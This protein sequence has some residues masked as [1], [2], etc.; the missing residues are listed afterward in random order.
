VK[1]RFLGT[2][3]AESKNT[4]LSTFI[5]DDIIAIESGSLTSEISFVEQE[6]IKAILLSHGHYDHIRGVPAFAF[7][8]SCHT[9]RVYATS[10]TLK[11]LS[12]HLV[13]GLIYPKFTEYTPICG[14]TSLEFVTIEPFIPIEI[15]GYKILALPVKHTLDAVGFE[16]TSKDGKK[17]FYT[18]DTGPGLS[19]IWKHVTSKQI[20]ID[21]T[22]PNKLEDTAKNS[23]HLCPNMLKEELLNFNRINGYFPEIILIHLT[24][25]FKREIRDEM[26]KI[27]EEINISFR[28]AKEGEEIII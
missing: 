12:S 22:F 6:K 8:N 7:N 28:I 9:T 15:E 4:K 1:I 25:K 3:N 23:K 14:K 19:G 18:G 5:I 20:I 13:D 11:I 10:P 27:A 24:P 17:I 21:L 26:K 16:I 2:H